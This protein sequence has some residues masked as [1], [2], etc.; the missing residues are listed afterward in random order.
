MSSEI[1]MSPEK[2]APG[3]R[4]GRRMREFEVR[5]ITL[6]QALHFEDDAWCD[7]FFGSFRTMNEKYPQRLI[8]LKWDVKKSRLSHDTVYWELITAGQTG[9]K[10]DQ[11][12]NKFNDNSSHKKVSRTTDP[13][14][15][16]PRMHG[17]NHDN[18][19]ISPGE[20]HD[21]GLGGRNIGVGTGRCANVTNYMCIH[22]QDGT[23]RVEMKRL[24]QLV[25]N[26]ALA[27]L[28]RI[29]AFGRG[30]GRSFDGNDFVEINTHGGGVPWLHVRVEAN[31]EYNTYTG[32]KNHRH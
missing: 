19:M 10:F 3:S 7:M 12:T 25:G 9:Y 29:P 14:P 31:P 22:G 13:D 27:R 24:W 30:R 15:Y 6:E 17:Q 18:V 11:A 21:V 32:D 20:G 4:T 26:V 5:G 16:A 23:S 1:S 28:D 2:R 8:Y